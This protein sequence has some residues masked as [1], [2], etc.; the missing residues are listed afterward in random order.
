MNFVNE[1]KIKE[2]FSDK[3][4]VES[5]MNMESAKDVQSAIASKGIELTLEDIQA[6]KTQLASDGEELSEDDLENVAGGFAIS[7][8]LIAIVSCCAA[9]YSVGSMVDN[10]TDR[11]W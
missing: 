3:A 6:L 8:T 2:I 9:T 10:L 4:F 7:S 1:Q 5:L 11:R